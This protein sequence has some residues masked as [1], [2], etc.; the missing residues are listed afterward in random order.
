MQEEN[1]EKLKDQLYQLASKGKDLMDLDNGADEELIQLQMENS[2]LKH[3][4]AILKRVR[5]NRSERKI[6]EFRIEI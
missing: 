2:K 5:N 6:N 4:Y 1:A 3:R